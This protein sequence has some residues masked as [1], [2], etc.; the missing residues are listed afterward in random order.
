MKL[1]TTDNI[2]IVFDETVSSGENPENYQLIADKEDV[3]VYYKGENEGNILSSA[4]YTF[5]VVNNSSRNVTV[6]SDNLSVNDF[7]VSASF[8]TDCAIGKMSNDTL[9]LYSSELEKNKIEKIDKI[10]FS[11]RC[12]DSDSYSEIWQEDKVVITMD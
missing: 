8:Y 3:Q 9:T 4:S 6:S 2:E 1:F 7:A 11:L 5:L 12:F 10:E